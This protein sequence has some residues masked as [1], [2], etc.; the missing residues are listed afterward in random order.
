MAK[1]SA[2]AMKATALVAWNL[3][4]LRVSRVLSQEALKVDASLDRSYVERIE[5]SVEKPTVQ[6]LVRLV[7]ALFSYTE[8]EGEA[9]DRAPANGKRRRFC[10]GPPANCSYGTL[11][12]SERRA[13]IMEM[14]SR[15]PALNAS[16]ASLDT[17]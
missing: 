17:H 6:V 4:L 2:G 9:A 10:S 15:A 16:A 13:T 12:A 1:P 3:R 7:K 8:V 5:R 11:G 14:L